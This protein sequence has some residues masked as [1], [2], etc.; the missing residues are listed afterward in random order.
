VAANVF[1]L[2]KWFSTTLLKGAK[3]RP[4]IL[5]E[6]CTKYF[7]ASQLTRFVLLH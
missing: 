2:Q 6:S 1:L 5:L 4:K 7:N 3:S